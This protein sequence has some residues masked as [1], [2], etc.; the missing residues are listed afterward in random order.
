[1]RAFNFTRRT[2]QHS[3]IDQYNRRRS[4]SIGKRIEDS[5]HRRGSSEPFVEILVPR[6]DKSKRKEDVQAVTKHVRIF[7]IPAECRDR[8]KKN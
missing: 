1:M 8:Y 3:R 2:C 6:Q 4:R 7:F 5:R